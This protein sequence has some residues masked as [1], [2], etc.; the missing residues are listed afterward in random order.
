M[1]ARLAIVVFFVTVTGC[2]EAIE[3]E[4]PAD[5]GPSCTSNEECSCGE[6]C[7]LGDG[8]HVCT[9][10]QPHACVDAR[11]CTAVP[12][13]CSQTQRLGHGC[14]YLECQP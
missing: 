14:G 8:G 5:A 3:H 1:T 6:R 13:V 9:P 10:Y 7:Q 2:Y 12:H 4:A 11:D